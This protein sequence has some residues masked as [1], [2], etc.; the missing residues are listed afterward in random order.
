VLLFIL[1]LHSVFIA[2]LKMRIPA[3]LIL[4]V[5]LLVVYIGEVVLICILFLSHRGCLLVHILC[6]LIVLIIWNSCLGVCL[7]YVA[8]ISLDNILLLLLLVFVKVFI[9]GIVCTST[10]WG[11][12][13]WHHLGVGYAL[14][15]ILACWTG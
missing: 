4:V 15:N 8:V 5:E 3:H 1:I 12:G 2:F 9:V 11:H 6:I 14:I 7:H 10:A 13:Y